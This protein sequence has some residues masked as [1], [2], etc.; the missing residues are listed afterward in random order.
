MKTKGRPQLKQFMKAIYFMKSEAIYY[1]FHEIR[2]DLLYISW[3]QRRS[4][5]NLSSGATYRF[6]LFTGSLRYLQQPIKCNF[7]RPS[8]H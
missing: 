3:N 7:N 1:I 8:E 5:H 2:G 6:L 4:T